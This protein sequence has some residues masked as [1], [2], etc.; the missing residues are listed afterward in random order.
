MKSQRVSLHRLFFLLSALFLFSCDG[1][2]Q[3]SKG[4]I[5]AKRATSE[6]ILRVPRSETRIF[7]VNANAFGTALGYSSGSLQVYSAE[8]KNFLN[9]PELSLDIP[10][11]ASSFVVNEEYIF[12]T[13]DAFGEEE[14]QLLVIPYAFEEGRVVL[15]DS[16]TFKLKVAVEPSENEAKAKANAKEAQA[17]LKPKYSAVNEK[18]FVTSCK[19]G[20]LFVLDLTAESLKAPVHV[21]NYGDRVTRSTLVLTKEDNFLLLFPG[22]AVLETSEG[23]YDKEDSST[24]AGD[25]TS[26]D[27]KWDVAKMG[28]SPYKVILFDLSKELTFKTLDAQVQ[29]KETFWL[30]FDL[31]G[32][33]SED[34]QKKFFRTHFSKAKEGSEDNTFYLVQKSVEEKKKISR[35]LK[36]KVDTKVFLAQQFGQKDVSKAL[37]FDEDP[38]FSIK[39]GEISFKVVRDGEE[40]EE[41]HDIKFVLDSFRI[42]DEAKKE[43]LVLSYNTSGPFALVK[44]SE[45][46]LYLL[47]QTKENRKAYKGLVVF[48]E[49]D[50]REYLTVENYYRFGAKL[51]LNPIEQKE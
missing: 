17:K 41:K 40:K 37:K 36:L 13:Y 23:N 43:A 22:V 3:D 21:R 4:P 8:D 24:G 46:S 38:F 50:N 31:K 16:Q 34:E 11:F 32:T 29:E 51:V 35:I 1:F 10:S 49:E 7:L 14:A 25:P 33:K 45:D 9:E 15:G 6:F 30:S 44:T 48:G 20:E 27:K 12:I 26:I 42:L 28:V 18:F 47:Q 2:E 5:G 19:G 39:E